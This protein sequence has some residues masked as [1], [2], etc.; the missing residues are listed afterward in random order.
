VQV[1]LMTTVRITKGEVLIAAGTPYSEGL[2]KGMYVVRTG[3]LGVFAQVRV[4]VH[5]T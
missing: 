2:G 3:K 4:C 1:P 5:D